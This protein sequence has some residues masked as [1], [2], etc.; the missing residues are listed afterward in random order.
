M[1]NYQV[2]LFKNRTKKKIINKFVTYKR[3]KQ[4]YDKLI[5][6]S[7][8]VVFETK[9]ENGKPCVY[10]LAIIGKSDD[11]NIPIFVT[12]EMGRSIKIDMDDSELEMIELSS[13]KV[14]EHIQDY[15]TNTKISYEFFEKK[16][17]SK[18]GLKMLSML[19]NKVVL[20]RDEE[21]FLF[22]LKNEE[23]CNRFLS[24]L[25]DYYLSINRMDVLIVRNVS[26]PN[27]KYLYQILQD[28][29]FDKKFLYRKTTTHPC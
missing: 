15:Q 21:M 2:V 13:Y 18:D 14:R 24:S 4:L 12:D 7:D 22:S 29:G 19:N 11:N 10:D 5:E 23:D 20:Q 27:K 1:S 26:S 17:L 8:K 28:R 25:E 16:Y 6:E 9:H 3:A